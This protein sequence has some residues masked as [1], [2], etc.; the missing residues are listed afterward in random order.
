MTL[1]FKKLSLY[2]LY[3]Y[4]ATLYSLAYDTRLN[5]ISKGMFILTLTF[6]CLHFV[7]KPRLNKGK[8]YIFMISFV[9]YS[10]FSCFWSADFGIAFNRNLTL[11]QILALVFMIYNIVETESELES[12][13]QSFFW[14]TIVMCGQTVLKYGLSTVLSMMIEGKRIGSDINQANAFGYYCAIA[15]LIAIYNVIYKKKKLFM[16]LALI[17]LVFSFASGSRKSILVVIA[18]TALII[19]LKNGKIRIS[20]IFGAL[21]LC[22]LLFAI[23]YNIEAL[24]PFFKRFTAMLNTFDNGDLGGGDNSIVTRMG[25]IRFGWDMFKENILFGY[26][27]EQYNVLYQAE[28]GL[29]RPSHNN[30]IQFLVCFGVVGTSLFYAMYVYVI[31]TTA[32]NIKQKEILATFVLILMITELT[33]QIT[34]DIFLNKFTYIYLALGFTYCN[35]TEQGLCINKKIKTERERSCTLHE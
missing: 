34:T 9:L 1:G 15:F 12:I 25:M 35:L 31:K 28:Y 32:K 20:R 27:T 10:T 26:G 14:G 2:S 17:P 23:L 4:I 19:A 16:V 33:N 21:A 7:T 5:L 18:A 11:Y 30:Y 13:F 29:F 22:I 6:F 8:I 24:Q 3:I